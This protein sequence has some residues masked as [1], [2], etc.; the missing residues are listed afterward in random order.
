MSDTARDALSQRL[1]RLLAAN[2]AVRD[3]RCEPRNRLPRLPE[4][5]RW[6]ADRLRDSFADFL[7]RPDTAPAANFF[8]SDLYGDHDVSARDRGI[9]RVIPL[10][11]RIL[12]Q[13]MVE[14]A[15]DAIELAVLSHA[16]DLRVAQALGD[17]PLDVASYGQAYRATGHPRLRARQIDLIVEVGA[18]LSEVVRT[19]WP[20][21]LLRAARLPAKA[22]GL[23]ALQSFLERGFAAFHALKDA[24]EFVQAIGERERETMRR[25]FAGGD[26]PFAV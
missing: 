14:I 19:P 7:G 25:L 17:A 6:Q 21:R 23:G 12:P 2:R 15:A 3:P 26:D 16:L 5:Q 10:M 4:L 20:A 1:A 22:A 8:L 24:P 18:G 11:Q 13:D 9:E